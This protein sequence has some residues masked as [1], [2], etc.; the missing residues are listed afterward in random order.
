MNKMT[1][2]TLPTDTL[3][4]VQKTTKRYLNHSEFKDNPDLDDLL[5]SVK[6]ELNQRDM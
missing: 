6:N 1:L 3:I 4:Q 2:K 5:D